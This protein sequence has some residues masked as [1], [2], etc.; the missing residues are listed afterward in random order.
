MG[1][2]WRRPALSVLHQVGVEIGPLCELGGMWGGHAAPFPVDLSAP[3][4]VVTQ[5]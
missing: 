1:E 5:V 2:Y 3:A 4:L